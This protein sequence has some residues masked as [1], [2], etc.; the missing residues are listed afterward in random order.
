LRLIIL[1]RI[2]QK[3]LFVIIQPQMKMVSKEKSLI[4][5]KK[6][7]KF[8]FFLIF[9]KYFYPLGYIHFD[10]MK[11]NNIISRGGNNI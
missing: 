11:V 9:N 6:K 10:R 4:T 2:I 3:N 1:Y 5:M 7:K 8:F